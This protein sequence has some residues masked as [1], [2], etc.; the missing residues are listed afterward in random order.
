MR[1]IENASSFEC[2]SEP[3]NVQH[4]IHVDFSTETGFRGLPP[5]W[6]AMLKSSGITRDEVR[7]NPDD[8]LK[9]LEFH[10]QDKPAQSAPA[11]APAALPDESPLTLGTSSLRAASASSSFSLCLSR[12]H[13]PR[14]SPLP[15]LALGRPTGQQRRPE[16]DLQRHEEDRR[17][18]RRRGVPCVRQVGQQGRRQEDA[19]QRR[20][21]QAAH[22]RDLDHEVEQPPEHCQLLRLVHCRGPALG[23]DGVHGRRLP[24]RGARAVRLGADDRAADGLRLQRDPQGPVVHSP[25]APYP[26]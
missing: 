8:V 26:S 14:F 9:V 10:F 15:F 7:E 20:E 25:A 16:P 23:R 12:S 22:H 1:A 11:P 2:V 6:D 17:G 21:S 18:C 3:F 4:N 13:I 5:E 24:H 19:T